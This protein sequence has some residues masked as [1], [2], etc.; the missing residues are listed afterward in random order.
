MESFKGWLR[1]AE[2]GQVM[3]PDKPEAPAVTAVPVY[4]DEAPPTPSANELRRR[5][6]CRRRMRRR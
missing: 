1:L 3:E 6:A 2:I 4:G 5:A